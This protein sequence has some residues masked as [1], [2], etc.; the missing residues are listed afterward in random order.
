ML[1]EQNPP[2]RTHNL[3]PRAIPTTS[4]NQD[5]VPQAVNN[6]IVSSSWWWA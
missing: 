1:L 4:Y 6:C 2:T 5:Y 3:Q